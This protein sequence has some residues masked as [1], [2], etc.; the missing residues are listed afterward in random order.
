MTLVKT[1]TALLCLFLL[2]TANA[3]T[4][5]SGPIQK[6]G[7][8]TLG[9]GATISYSFMM[10]GEQ[11]DTS[12]CSALDSFMPLGFQQE[13]KKAFN[14]WSSVADL[15]FIELA[16]DGANFNTL[17]TSGDIRIGGEMIDGPSGVLAHAFYPDTHWYF[18]AGGDLHFDT[19]ETWSIDGLVDGISIFWVALHEIGHSLGL[20]HSDE[21]NAIM[22][23][24][25]NPVL[26][27]LQADDIAGIQYLYGANIS[28]VPVPAAFWLLSSAL[29]GLCGLRRKVSSKN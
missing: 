10:G 23:P 2:S 18:S 13:I 24:Y 17:T 4:L 14:A 12:T 7:D 8:P 26:A 16:D 3:Y 21:S 20:G 27:G 1:F 9:T 6:W 15:K 28:A 25:Y 11:C 22:G 5:S 29:V 19:S